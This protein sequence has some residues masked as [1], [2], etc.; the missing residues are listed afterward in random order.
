[1][2]PPTFIIY[3]GIAPPTFTSSKSQ[4][5]SCRYRIQASSISYMADDRERNKSENEDV[6]WESTSP[7]ATNN[8]VENEGKENLLGL[9]DIS[10]TEAEKRTT[11]S[12]VNFR[13]VYTVYLVETRIPDDPL[14]QGEMKVKLQP[15]CTLWRRYSDFETLRNYLEIAYPFVIIPPLP[16]KKVM[17][18]WQNLAVDKFDPDFIDRRRAGL[19]NFLLR[20]ASHKVLAFDAVFIGFLQQEDGWKESVATASYISKADAKLKS[21][22]ASLMLKRPDKRF[23]EIKNYSGELHGNISNLLKIRARLADRLYG[24]HKFHAN[25]GRVFSEWSTLEKQMGDALQKAGHFMDAYAAA[26]D[27]ML[28]EEE[29]FSDQM[30]EYLFYADAL[31]MVCKKQELLQYDIERA[32][33]NLAAKTQQRDNLM[34]GKTSFVSRWLTNVDTDEVRELKLQQLDDQIREAESQF[35]YATSESEKFA[36]KA[37]VSVN[38]F[39]NQKVKDLKETL[40]SYAIMQIKQCKKGLSI[41]SNIRDCF[42][43]M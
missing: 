1:M 36:E 25:Y 8:S 11:G 4:P 27:L 37:I 6:I 38:A 9:L 40:I 29:Q 42:N 15:S 43:T 41:W 13:D 30:K 19:E 17:F 34:R 16:E 31:R 35:S 21:L 12:G 24:I 14:P 23:E 28:E 7:R 39:H 32:E 3:S 18:A 2:S 5:L 26:I 22:S 20:V 33:E 10:V